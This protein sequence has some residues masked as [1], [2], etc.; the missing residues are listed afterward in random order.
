MDFSVYFQFITLKGDKHEVTALAKSP[1]RKHVAVG[2]NDG[3]IKVF[4]IASGDLEVNFSGHK[5]TVTTLTYDQQGMRLVSGGKV[6][7]FSFMLQQMKKH[8]Q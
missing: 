8:I 6:S 3:M 5:S 2:Y 4:D 7:W 1:D